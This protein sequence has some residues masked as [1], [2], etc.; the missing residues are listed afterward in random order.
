M[1]DNADTNVFF[2]IHTELNQGMTALTGSVVE[3]SGSYV[4]A[5][6]E[7]SNGEFIFRAEGLTRETI[8]AVVLMETLTGSGTTNDDMRY[9]FRQSAL[10]GNVHKALGSVELTIGGALT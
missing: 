4:R 7:S 5:Q 6:A 1:A 9:G 2:E 10:Y 8:T 3:V